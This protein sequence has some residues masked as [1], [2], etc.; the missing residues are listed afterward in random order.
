MAKYRKK[1]MEVDAIQVIYGQ[2]TPNQVIKE[3]GCNPIKSFRDEPHIGTLEGRM[4]ISDGD[5]VI[6][7]VKGE[8]YPS[9]AD[10]FRATY[11]EVSP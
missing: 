4:L 2:T 8:Y 11:E 7:G 10:I 1:P 9:K 6:R 5:Y 3:L